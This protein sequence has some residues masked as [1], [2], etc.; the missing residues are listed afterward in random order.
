MSN[1]Q[2]APFVS[3]AEKSSSSLFA[4]DTYFD[5]YNGALNRYLGNAVNSVLGNTSSDTAITT[6]SQGVTQILNQYAAPTQK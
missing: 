2:L 3:Q 5:N 1:P 4:S 6:L